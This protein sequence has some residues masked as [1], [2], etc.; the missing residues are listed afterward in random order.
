MNESKQEPETSSMET[1][2]KKVRESY[3]SSFKFELTS[4]CFQS[5][6][7]WKI[8]LLKNLGSILSWDGLTW[9]A[10]SEKLSVTFF[11]KFEFQI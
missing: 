7:H 8:F 10:K 11:D 9:L 5:K 2:A 6:F 4:V 3:T 1:S